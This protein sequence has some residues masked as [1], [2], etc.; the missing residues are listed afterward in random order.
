MPI[1]TTELTVHQLRNEAKRS[2]DQA[3]TP[4]LSA[5]SILLLTERTFQEARRSDTQQNLRDAYYKYLQG[6]R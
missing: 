4:G 3:L 5:A 6:A 2:T 1:A